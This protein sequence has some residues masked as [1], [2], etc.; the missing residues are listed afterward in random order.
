[1]LS[2]YRADGASDAGAGLLLS[3]LNPPN[4]G[5]SRK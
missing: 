1:M 2:G 4:R 3:G 5:N